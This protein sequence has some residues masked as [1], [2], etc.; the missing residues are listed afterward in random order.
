MSGFIDS[1]KKIKT[2]VYI[3]YSFYKCI[4]VCIPTLIEK[5]YK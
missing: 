1:K 5:D 2:N 3:D 4:Y